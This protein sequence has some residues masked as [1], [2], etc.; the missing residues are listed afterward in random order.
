[1]TQATTHSGHTK[2]ESAAKTKNLTDRINDLNSTER[3]RED[4]AADILRVI[5]KLHSQRDPKDVAE[6]AKI[7]AQE[8]NEAIR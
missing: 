8:Y 5:Q 2:K 4:V 6:G 3:A 7:A 1:M